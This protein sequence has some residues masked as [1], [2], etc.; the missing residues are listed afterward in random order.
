MGVPAPCGAGII[1]LLGQD[2]LGVERPSA[3][4]EKNVLIAHKRPLPNVDCWELLVT[5]TLA[6]RVLAHIVALVAQA[7]V[8][9]ESV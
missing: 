9:L 8:D 2:R 4:Q 1:G 3:Q 6:Q 7:L 5:D